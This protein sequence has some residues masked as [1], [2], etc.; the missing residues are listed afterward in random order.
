MLPEK[1]ARTPELFGSKSENSGRKS[2]KPA[3]K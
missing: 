1:F 3:S 2:K